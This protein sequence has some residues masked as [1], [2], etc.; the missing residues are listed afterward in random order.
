[1][2][3]ERRTCYFVE[4]D[5]FRVAHEGTSE[6]ETSLHSTRQGVAKDL[7]GCFEIDESEHFV[8][9]L[10]SVLSETSSGGIEL[11]LFFESQ[12]IEENVVLWTIADGL[13]ELIDAMSYVMIDSLFVFHGDCAGCLLVDSDQAI[14]DG[15]FS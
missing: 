1:M 12:E 3:G 9:N 10:F 11:E 2:V 14:E 5:N 15:G 6:G 13:S 7:S 4:K 8:G